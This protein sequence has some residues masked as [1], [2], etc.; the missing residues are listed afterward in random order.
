MNI[1]DEAESTIVDCLPLDKNDIFPRLYLA[2]SMEKH[3]KQL[4]DDRWD[5][6]QPLGN[7]QDLN[8]DDHD[9]P[10]NMGYV[11]AT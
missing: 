8:L 1:R 10:S 5:R 3:L 11:V 2:I 4:N 9:P 7:G 6:A